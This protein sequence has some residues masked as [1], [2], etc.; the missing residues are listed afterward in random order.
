MEFLSVDFGMNIEIR[1]VHYYI[2]IIAL[3]FQLQKSYVTWMFHA[4]FFS[5][6]VKNIMAL[7]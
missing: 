4:F 2:R 1:R 6:S 3:V 5:Y 7:N